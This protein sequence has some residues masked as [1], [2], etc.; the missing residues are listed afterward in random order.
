[1]D[2][3]SA[4]FKTYEAA[5]LKQPVADRKRVLH[6]IVNFWT[7]GSARLVVDLFENM[8]H[9]YEQTVLTKDIPDVPA[10]TG[11]PMIIDEDTKESGSILNKLNN[12]KPDLVHIHYLGH[13]RDKWGK[14]SWEWYNKIFDIIEELDCPVIENVNIP[15][16]PFE[17]K[18]VSYYVYVSNF[19]REKFAQPH[20][21][22]KVIY[23]GSDFTH[24]KKL[25]PTDI[26]DNCIGMVY[27]L[28]RDKINE[29]SI[30]VFI[31]VVKK[32]KDTNVLIVGGGSLLENYKKAVNDAGLSESFTF[33]GYVAYNDLPQYYNKMSVF[34]A[35]V[36]RESFGQVTPMA[37]NMGI[38]VVGYDVGAIP[39]IIAN[40]RLLADS[41]DYLQLSEIIINLLDDRGKRLNI[42][43]SNQLRA[44]SLFSVEAMIQSYEKIYQ[45]VLSGKSV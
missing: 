10:Y 19:V 27:R 24:F 11:F 30:K 20:H 15:T 36:H 18:I 38:P 29:E 33:T 39:E 17:N 6:V 13:Q 7:G 25:K 42:G 43:A 21:Q 3:Y 5:I 26:P 28:E 41:G 14:K 34:V 1:M 35:P 16:D 12:F 9:V 22:N 32:R 31:E 2:N 37:M 8:G 44:E 45:E 40:E 23:P 4:D